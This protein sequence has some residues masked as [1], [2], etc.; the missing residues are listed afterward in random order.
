LNSNHLFKII[1]WNVGILLGGVVLVEAFFGDW[2]GAPQLWS[3]NIVRDLNIQFNVPKLYRRNDLVHYR[4]DKRG[5]RG[6]YGEVDKINIVAFGGSTTEEGAVSED[7]TWPAILN[8]CLRQNNINS[9]M[10]NAGIAGQSSVGHILNFSKWVNHIP[11]FS[12]KIALFL[13]GYNEQHLDPNHQDPHNIGGNTTSKYQA[14][15]K[16]VKINSAIYNLYR[17][18]RGN[19]KAWKVGLG[20]AQNIKTYI[21]KSEKTGPSVD[22]RDKLYG[23]K[24]YI[25]MSSSN[26]IEQDKIIREKQKKQMKAYKN[27]LT[28]LHQSAINFNINP[29]YVTQNSWG[30][31]RD[32]NRIYGSLQTYLRLNAFNDITRNF[33][34]S[35]NLNC[36]DVAN[37]FYFGKGDLYDQI[38]STP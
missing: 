14:F 34:R 9:N 16:W 27:R 7:E 19:I 36:V 22:V 25:E 28:V 11:N 10:A 33:C 5:F 18:I 32:K 20:P 1:T 26:F 35:N 6:N 4:K 29:I 30:Y 8:S 31:W 24:S 21:S 17:V 12:P 23:S 13:I 37:K 38:H 15:R 2:F 3:L